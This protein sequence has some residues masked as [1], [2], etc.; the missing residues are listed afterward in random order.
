LREERKAKIAEMWQACYTQEEI[1][2]AVGME[3]GS[4]VE[5]LGEM[6]NLE[7]FPKSAKLSALYQGG[8]SNQVAN[9]QLEKL[10]PQ[11]TDSE[12]ALLAGA[13][14]FGLDCIGTIGR[15]NEQI[16]G[17]AIQ[18]LTELFQGACINAAA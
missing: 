2:E 14:C 16:A 3:R 13:F 17:L 5:I 4:L 7:A 8:K 15:V 1:A 12:S 10:P 11:A 18:E 6:Q 9:L